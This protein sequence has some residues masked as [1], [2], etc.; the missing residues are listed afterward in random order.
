MTSVQLKKKLE[1]SAITAYQEVVVDVFPH[2]YYN[3]CSGFPPDR[4]CRR[5][6][7]Q[8]TKNT[9]RNGKKDILDMPNLVLDPENIF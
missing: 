6:V 1:I 4:R 5:A 7:P 9:L 3:L 2:K 8:N